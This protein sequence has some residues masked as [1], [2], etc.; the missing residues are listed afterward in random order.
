MTTTNNLRIEGWKDLLDILGVMRGGES[1][2]STP[3]VVLKTTATNVVQIEVKVYN[4]DTF[5]AKDDCVAIFD[6]LR[7]RYGLAK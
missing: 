4:P 5:K 2:E 3:S 6:E 7:V 1:N